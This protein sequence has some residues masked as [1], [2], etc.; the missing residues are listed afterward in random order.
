MMVLPMQNSSTALVKLR[1]QVHKKATHVL[2]F[3]S[4]EAAAAKRIED[5]EDS[6]MTGQLTQNSNG[7]APSNQV[8]H[9]FHYAIAKHLCWNMVHVV[10]LCVS[11]TAA[12]TCLWYSTMCISVPWSAGCP[13][14]I[15]RQQ[16]LQSK[17]VARK[18]LCHLPG[19]RDV[20]RK[21]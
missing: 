5:D 9:S 15:L 11:T 18:T 10:P 19:R 4:K 2:V 17:T 8:Q 13:R 14:T 3:H 12:S 6:K 21:R 1:H 20:L 16:G 7:S